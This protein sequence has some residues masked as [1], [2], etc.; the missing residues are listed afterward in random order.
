MLT[1]RGKR[2]LLR[3]VL[4]LVWCGLLS[5]SLVSAGDWPMWRHDA[6][7]S[8]A[9]PHGLPEELHL[10]WLRTFPPPAPAWPF[11]GA[12]NS[13][14]LNFDWSYEPIVS[15]KTLF[16]GSSR[17]DTLT[18]IDTETGR[19]KWTFFADGPVRLAPVAWKNKVY[20]TSD[21]GC[22]YCVDTA[23]GTLLWKFDGAPTG[24]KLLG[25]GRLISAW[26]ARGGPVLKEGR[27]Y[28]ASGIWPFMGVF[29]YCVDAE[30][31]EV[32]WSNDESGHQQMAPQ[33]HLVVQG[34][35]LIVP[36]GQ[37]LPGLFDT[38]SG[39]MVAHPFKVFST[40][41]GCRPR[42]DGYRANAVFASKKYYSASGTAIDLVSGI[43]VSLNSKTGGKVSGLGSNSVVKDGVLY[44]EYK[45]NLFAF[46]LDGAPRVETAFDPANP[47][48]TRYDAKR[49]KELRRFPDKRKFVQVIV[50]NLWTHKLKNRAVHG[51]FEARKIIA[52]ERLYHGVNRTVTVY[53]LSSKNEARPIQTITVKGTIGSLAAA[54]DRLFI[55]TQ[56]GPMY[57]YGGRKVK[58]KTWA[59]PPEPPRG[60]GQYM[61][62]VGFKNVRRLSGFAD[63]PDNWV[64]FDPD[65]K[66]VENARRELAGQGLYG[67]RMHVLAGDFLQFELPQYLASVILVQDPQVAKRLFHEKALAKTFRSLRPYGG[68]LRLPASGGSLADLRRIAKAAKLEQ[69]SVWDAGQG[70]VVERVGALPGAADWT[71]HEADSGNTRFSADKLVKPPFGVLWFG[72]SEKIRHLDRHTRH[73]RPL[74]AGGRLFIQGAGELNAEDIY[75]GRFLWKKEV[76]LLAKP[77]DTWLWQPGAQSLGGNTVALKDAVYVVT[78]DKSE[79][80][81]LDPV[82]GETVARFTIPDKTDPTRTLRWGYVGAWKDLLI[83]GVDSLDATWNYDYRKSTF[84]AKAVRKF[85]SHIETWK[86]FTKLPRHKN[87]SELDF[88]LKNLNKL[89]K[90]RSILEVLP[91]TVKDKADKT[92]LKALSEQISTVKQMSRVS[93]RQQLR[94]LAL[95]REML[96]LLYPELPVLSQKRK[97]TY[98]KP[99]GW[100]T[101]EDAASRELVVMNRHSGH[102]LWRHAA[103]SCFR[104][105]AIVAGGGRVYT[106]DRWPPGIG[107]KGPG[108]L[109]ALDARTGRLLWR[110]TKDISGGFLAYSESKDVLVQS[111]G[112]TNLQLVNR[113]DVVSGLTAY[114]GRDGSVLWHRR[115]GGSVF[116]FHD[117][118]LIAPDGKRLDILTGRTL[119]GTNPLT[120]ANENFPRAALGGC[121]NP[122]GSKYLL[123]ARAGCA[124]QHLPRAGSSGFYCLE[125]PLG[126]QHL[127]GFR[128]SCMADLIPAG[129]LL[130]SPNTGFG[131]FCLT[132]QV[133]G[134]LAVVHDPDAENWAYLNNRYARLPE[135]IARIGVNFGAPGYTVAPNG[136]LWLAYPGIDEPGM[137]PRRSLQEGL[138]VIG[139]VDYYYR[140]SLRLRGAGLRWVAASG[141]EGIEKV[142]LALNPKAPGAQYTV[143]LH[144]AEPRD[145]RPGERVFDVKLQGKA[146]LAN[147]DV[148]K[149]AGTPQRALVREFTDVRVGKTLTVELI[150]KTKVPPILSG[151]EAVLQ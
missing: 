103:K 8:G 101:W 30:T 53:D 138:K 34:N 87:E 90:Q 144:F 91:D 7:R 9:S 137:M 89:I 113:R 75:T 61:I 15:G 114:R 64:A 96:N 115:A 43:R 129:G 125:E 36:C 78:G 21:D 142:S 147:L 126:N 69:T 80:L 50:S 25:N 97:R 105:S 14:K 119:R 3:L 150:G 116:I 132:D 20:F 86:N 51:D 151:V 95:N 55:A 1:N 98:Y 120:G 10:Q 63:T 38:S 107:Q 100:F 94:L 146:V 131:C 44:A 16:V 56:E 130:N 141:G 22:L 40:T 83:G 68:T 133:K 71:H 84:P 18:A 143:R 112:Y 32:V 24:R 6:S 109:L 88:V 139:D 85:S 19:V 140:H 136:T 33:G 59:A 23:K 149:D 57:C 28:F 111:F 17:S 135:G 13:R 148:V 77:F 41:A 106:I 45:A 74:V 108:E 37:G 65:T 70:F 67:R 54:D 110:K 31:G 81:K 5:G 46:D 29:L 2:C 26:P 73:P 127:G 76:P 82:T 42:F 11:D 60:S 102:L 93:R 48:T 47:D 4:L 72:A 122:I 27:I 79:C 124:W 128:A 145:L 35:R 62:L 123:T 134:T 121:G 49:I 117:K 66:K 92:R 39:K 58:A 99:G 52:G 104:H 12:G 118:Y